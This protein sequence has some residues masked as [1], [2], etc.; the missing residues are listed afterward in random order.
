MASFESLGLY[1]S[2]HELEWSLQVLHAS[3]PGALNTQGFVEPWTPRVIKRK[4][5]EI[6]LRETKFYFYSQSKW[7][8]CIDYWIRND[9]MPYQANLDA[10]WFHCSSWCFMLQ[11]C[12][13]GLETWIAGNLFSQLR[14][15]LLFV[16]NCW[17]ER[18]QF[19]ICVGTQ[20]FAFVLCSLN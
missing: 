8:S 6:L 4:K 15:I 18:V 10:E 9:T 7:I 16:F 5:T 14:R 1:P 3:W 20:F 17:K 19:Y 13:C 2:G 11:P 12:R